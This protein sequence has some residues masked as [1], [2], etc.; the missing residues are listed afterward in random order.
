MNYFSLRY[1]IMFIIILISILVHLFF[2]KKHTRKKIIILIILLLIIYQVIM[3]IPI[4]EHFIKFDTL[5]EA[6]N[7]SYSD[8]QIIQVVEKDEY[9][10]VICSKNDGTTKRYTHF[11]KNN[12][13]WTV[14]SPNAEGTK[15][16]ATSKGFLISVNKIKKKNSM[17]V[18]IGYF[19]VLYKNPD[20][21]DSINSD[22]MLNKELETTE[23]SYYLR[24]AIIEDVPEDY[25]LIIEGEKIKI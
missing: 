16:K 21:K 22:F 20:I 6:F 14:T 25:Y 19:D 12:E 2:I 17:L 24:I 5:E 15:S 10:F 8:Y 11:I 7:Y 18:S 13:K 4:E 23:Y 1:I 3:V 9:A